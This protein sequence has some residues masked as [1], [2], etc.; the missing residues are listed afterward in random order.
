MKHWIFQRIECFGDDIA[1]VDSNIEYSYRQ[2]LQR[3]SQWLKRL[4]Q[5]KV[6]SGIS[7][8]LTSDYTFNTCALMLAL[9]ENNNIVVPL[10]TKSSSDKT[11][12]LTIGEVEGYYIFDGNDEAQYTAIDTPRAHQLLQD[13]RDNNEPGLIVFSSGSTGE[14]KASLHSFNRVLNKFK[15]QRKAYRSLVFLLLDHLGGINTLFYILCNGGVVV[16][17]GGRSVKEVCQ[18][19][20]KYR[21]ELL[22]TTPT[23]LKM[24]LINQAA[25]HY[26]LSSLKLITY[27]A[28]PMHEATLVQLHQVFNTVRLQ[29]TYGLSEVGALQTKSLES[30]S[31]WVKVGGSEYQTKV[32]NGT[33]HIRAQNAMLGYL[34]APSPFD[35]DGWMDTQDSVEQKGEYLRILGRVTEII[36]VGGEKVYPIE[37]EDIIQQLDNVRDVVVYGKKNPLMGQIVF[38]DIYLFEPEPVA[39]VESRVREFCQDKLADFKIPV[40][41]NVYQEKE[42][43]CISN[44]FKKLRIN[45]E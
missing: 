24:L 32:I 42:Q 6:T 29:Q 37:V 45:H 34:N 27:G 44:R 41:A 21:I 43:H 22:P 5:D 17:A 2:L 12:L 7:V 40:I 14:S 20:E 23:F 16:P 19:I 15:T 38:A 25:S 3:V 31:L 35:K 28:E 39:E 13:L 9:I 11:R 33:L 26:D 1:M 18:R 8:A 36:N 30:G 10:T 4:E